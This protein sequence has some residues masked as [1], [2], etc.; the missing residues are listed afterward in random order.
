MAASCGPKPEK[1]IKIKNTL[2]TKKKNS[3][4]PDK[5]PPVPGLP[6]QVLRKGQ[7][8]PTRGA[9]HAGPAHAGPVFWGYGFRVQGLGF[10][11]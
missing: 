2:N 4:T 1:K 5:R 6:D 10:R 7:A 11:V 8:E 9:H 3:N